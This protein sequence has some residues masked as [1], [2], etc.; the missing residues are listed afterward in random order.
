MTLHDDPAMWEMFRAEVDTHMS[1]LNDGLLALERDPGQSSHFERLMRAA[2]SIK[3]AAKIM[4]AGAAVQIAHVIEDSFVAARDGQL[5]MTSALID[6]L[7]EGVDLLGTVAH[8][9]MLEPDDATVARVREVAERIKHAAQAGPAQETLPASR[10]AGPDRSAGEPIAAELRL[11][12]TLNAAWI[13]EHHARI[14]T[15]I[16]SAIA[17]VHLDCS[18]VETIDASGLAWLT[19]L[20]SHLNEH[21]DASR[22]KICLDG[23]APHWQRVLRAT[24]VDRVCDV[25][26]QER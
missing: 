21:A 26:G 8:R 4:G 11:G 18:A 1:A 22:I 10:T 3:G 15:A 6:V 16:Q 9:E 7:L 5:T 23:V 12:R 2:H 24:G 20:G 17:N 19:W 14:T 13:R 25:S